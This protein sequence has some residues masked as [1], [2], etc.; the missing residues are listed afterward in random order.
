MFINTVD[1]RSFNHQSRLPG[2]SHSKFVE[3]RAGQTDYATDECTFF[4]C[5]TQWL[6]AL[7]L[8]SS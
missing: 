7:D 5:P 4:S 6:F 8:H 1:L 3:S 2:A